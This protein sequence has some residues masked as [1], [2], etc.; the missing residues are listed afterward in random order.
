[1]P[2]SYNQ[3]SPSLVEVFAKR[4][5]SPNQFQICHSDH[6]GCLSLVF[7][8]HAGKTHLWKG[9]GEIQ[10]NE[11]VSFKYDST[12]IRS[13]I[14]KTE[15]GSVII[16]DIKLNQATNWS[17]KLTMCKL[18]LKNSD[19][20]SKIEYFPLTNNDT[21]SQTELIPPGLPP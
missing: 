5:W 2:I 11:F 15:M 13:P 7:D 14:N 3:K 8:F 21:T 12:Q 10:L 18:T 9:G 17:E 16:H 1:M 20:I 4:N 19:N 6:P